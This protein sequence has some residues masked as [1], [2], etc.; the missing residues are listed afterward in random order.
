MYKKD[1]DSL[2]EI[3]HFLAFYGDI[4][5]LQEYEKVIIDKFKEDNIIKFYFDDYDFEEIKN[6]LLEGSLFGGKNIVIIKHNKIPP[7]IDKLKQYAKENYLFFFYYGN[8]KLD[9]SSKNV[10]RF[11]EP[12]LRDKFLIIEQI[13]NEYNITLTKEAVEFLA[14][15]IEPMFYRKEIEKLSLF[16]DHLVLEDVKKL[17]FLYKEDSFEDLF[18]SILKKEDFFDKLFS[19]IEIVDFKRIIPALIRYINDLYQYNLYIKKT[20]SNSLKDFLGYQLPYDIEKQRVSL[21]IKFKEKDYLELLKNLLEFELKMRNSEKNK[22]AIF[23]EA[24]IFLKTFNSF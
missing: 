2:K 18:V 14:K 9:F 5:Y 7:N 10:V 21:A 19:F 17:I 20:G 23:F 6:Y 16:S 8:K 15:S 3:P 22:E 24:M 4:F 13:A 1:F 12:S 11:F